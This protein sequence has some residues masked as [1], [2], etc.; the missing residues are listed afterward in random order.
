MGGRLRIWNM[1]LSD[2]LPLSGLGPFVNRIEIGNT[3]R[4][5]VWSGFSIC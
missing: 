5:V 3:P 4:W 1:P 2:L